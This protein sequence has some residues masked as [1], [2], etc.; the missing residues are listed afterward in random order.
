MTIMISLVG[1][2]PVPNLLPVRYLQPD[3][4]ILLTTSRTK[5]M[6]QRLSQLVQAEVSFFQVDPYAILE[7]RDLLSEQLQTTRRNTEP[8]IFNFTGGTKNMALAAYMVALHYRAPLVYFQTEG[9]HSLLHKYHFDGHELAVS[10]TSIIPAL[11]TNNDYIYAHVGEYQCLGFYHETSDVLG[12]Q[13]ERQ[14]HDTLLPHVD[15]ITVGVKPIGELDID[16]VV[17]CGNQV[18]LVEV[19][20]GKNTRKGIDQLN[21]AGRREYFG[22][23]TE[24]FLVSNFDWSER[25]NQ[26]ELADKAGDTIHIIELKSFSAQNPTIS[27]EDAQILINVIRRALGV[28]A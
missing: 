4:L 9:H 13:F 2:Q 21:T 3:K 28:G 26:Q 12:R 11:L 6:A 16:L 18:G 5:L 24:R 22:T 15:E 8:L 23:Y 19:K 1:E 10:E 7:T 25:G 17:R 14:V 27:A 20:S